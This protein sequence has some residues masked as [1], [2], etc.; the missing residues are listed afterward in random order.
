MVLD[1]GVEPEIA[2]VDAYVRAEK[3]VPDRPVSG[4]AG[5]DL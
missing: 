4:G 2:A 3:I 5:I 1:Q